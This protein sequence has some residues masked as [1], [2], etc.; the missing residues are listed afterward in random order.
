MCIRDSYDGVQRVARADPSGPRSQADVAV[1][2]FRNN[3]GLSSDVT[4]QVFEDREGN[5]WIGTER[6]L[7]KF[8]PATLRAEPGLRSPA[9]FGDKLMQASDG[10]VYIGEA[11]TIYR[12]APGGEPTPI[13]QDVREP[14][15]ICEAPDGGVWIAFSRRIVVWKDG[16]VRRSIERPNTG[17]VH[18]IIY[19]CAFDG[20]G[21]YWY[22]AGGAGMYRY[23]A[24]RWQAMFGQTDV[25]GFY[26]MTLVS[27]PKGRLIVQWGRR[28]LAWI[29]PSTRQLTP[30]N[31]GAGP[32][33]ASG[34]ADL[35]EGGPQPLTVYAA[36]GGD[37]FVAGASGLSR[38]RAGRFQTLWPDGR[39]RSRRISG[40]VQ[41]P[42]GDTWIAFP[43]TLER[44]RAQDLER[45]F[46]EGAFP[47]P[48]VSLGFGDGLT[49]RTHSHTQRSIVRGGDG[50]L[51]IA[52][53][54]GAVWMDPTR[55]VRD[56][57]QPGVAIRSVTADRRIYRDPTALRLREATSNVEIDYAVLSF[58]DPRNAQVRY[59]L[60]GFDKAWLDPGA[61]RQ[62][63]YTNLPLSL[64]HI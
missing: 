54:T 39:P 51:W 6:G 47:R 28:S 49:S 10:S 43:M 50:R 29:D 37:V 60:E 20:Q 44:F 16:R 58:A 17:S 61:R 21:D 34:P 64:I 1:E 2:S 56:D 23:R 53:E 57:L 52:T 25:D 40:L 38:F 32:P 42:E 7:D 8:R 30:L 24:G 18:G 22:A 41:T 27:D 3:D 26:P 5:V 55:I 31:F 45:A 9:A 33:R 11:R 62:A 35:G 46:S 4:N 48:S 15:S 14:Q 12:V 63:F 59:R 36:G 13:L 19:D